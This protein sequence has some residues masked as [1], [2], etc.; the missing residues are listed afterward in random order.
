MVELQVQPM[1]DPDIIH[2]SQK[3]HKVHPPAELSLHEA[4]VLWSPA[5]PWCTAVPVPAPPSMV[6]S[7]EGEECPIYEFCPVQWHIVITKLQR[8]IP[9]QKA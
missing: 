1:F 7:E 5:C 2:S 4:V 9:I 8:T 3:I 6:H